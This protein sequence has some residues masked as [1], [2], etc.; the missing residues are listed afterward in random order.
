MIGKAIKGKSTPMFCLLDQ[1]WSYFAVALREQHRSP[2]KTISG[3]IGVHQSVRNP[4]IRGKASLVQENSNPICQDP[5]WLV[6][7]VIRH[8]SPYFPY[9]VRSCGF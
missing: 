9:S 7:N 6:N 2:E 5:F 3:Q 8:Y 1:R 4:S